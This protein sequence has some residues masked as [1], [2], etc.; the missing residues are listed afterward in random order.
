MLAYSPK[1][2]FRVGM[3]CM[4][5]HLTPVAITRQRFYSL[6]GFEVDP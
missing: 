2:L 1:E 6:A 3:S 4:D 5:S